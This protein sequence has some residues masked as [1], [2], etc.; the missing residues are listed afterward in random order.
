MK[1]Y[2]VAALALAAAG[3]LAFGGWTLSRRAARSAPPPGEA[4]G[5]WHVHTTRSDGR[6]TLDEVVRAARA[7]G[8]QFVVVADHNA[9]TPAEAGYRDG[10]LVIEATE[11][12]SV[13]GHVVAVG[14]P[15]APGAPERADPLRRTAAEGGSAVLAHP[16]HP[17]RPF[18]GWGQ[19]PWRGFEVVSDDSF[20]Y[21][22]LRDRAVGRIALAALALPFDAPQAVL[23]ISH[24][25]A[26]ELA[27]FDAEAAASRA[28]GRPPPVLFC[29]A[30][31]HGY[32]SYGAAFEAFSMHVP[33]T[34]TGDA[35]RDTRA[36]LGALFDGSAACVYDG[37]APGAAVRLARAPGGGLDL[38]LQ[39]PAGC[40]VRLRL[41]R[42]GQEVEVRTARQG[43]GGVRFCE[44][45]CAPGTYRAEGTVD[46]RP[47]LFTN[48]VAIE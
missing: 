6:G 31:A 45:G 26:E 7:A 10:V 2:L 12:S 9:L 38:S 44:A 48:P 34:L 47:W 40:D 3:W 5:A 14:L 35:A 24:F 21:Q 43:P 1:R 15:R 42:D 8:L 22:T 19:G 16:F 4:R 20:W 17:R 23:W 25:P 36:V 37:V 30:D 33:V 27:R 32:P 46:G 18:T 11:I 39:A 41:L 28:D 29:S 13:F